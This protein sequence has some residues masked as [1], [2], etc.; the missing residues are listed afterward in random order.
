M[1]GWGDEWKRK[2]Q[3]RP[4][5]GSARQNHPRDRRPTGGGHR[6]HTRMCGKR[7]G[8]WTRLAHRAPGR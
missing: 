5:K 6:S 8:A 2:D 4:W 3:D 1:A 7:W